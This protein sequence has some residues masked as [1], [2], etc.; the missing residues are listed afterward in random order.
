MTPK[1]LKNL[2]S[3]GQ[4]ALVLDG[5]FEQLEQLSGQL[6]RLEIESETG[7]ERE[8]EL[9]TRFSET[10]TRVGD[11]MQGLAKSLEE[12]RARAEK[13]TELVAARAVKIQARQNE[14]DQM[15]IRFQTLG[16]TVRKVS[17][18]VA[19]LQKPADGRKLSDE[20]KALLLKNLP[21]IKSQLGVLT[22]EAK[23]LKD[24]ARLAKMK[25]LEKNADSLGQSLASVI[26]KLGNLV[27]NNSQSANTDST[28]NLH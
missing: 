15:L 23:K 22:E 20:E 6:E 3:F 25:T 5:D 28:A 4:S 24:D 9:L 10:A 17:G 7:M 12:A 21:E 13:A 14:N 27:G 16:E 19:Q 26:S 2:S 18:A 11:S 1:D 8:K